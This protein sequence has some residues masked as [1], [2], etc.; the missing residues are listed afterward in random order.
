MIREWT[1]ARVE[2]TIHGRLVLD[3][4]EGVLVALRRCGIESAFDELVNVAQR[5]S[6]PVFALASALVALAAG[7]ESA[8]IDPAARSAA[9]CEWG[10]LLKGC[11]DASGHRR[12]AAPPN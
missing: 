7:D 6:I 11:G 12:S 9:Q 4:A 10:E 5:T 3:T 2:R 1:V 8:R